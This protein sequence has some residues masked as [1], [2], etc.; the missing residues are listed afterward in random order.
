MDQT[1]EMAVM[2]ARKGVDNE[3]IERV[4]SA[5]RGHVA[6]APIVTA[7]LRERAPYERPVLRVK[8]RKTHEHIHHPVLDGIRVGLIAHGGTIEATMRELVEWCRPEWLASQA[9]PK[10]PNVRGLAAVVA[11]ARL[12]NGGVIR[13][14]RFTFLRVD[15]RAPHG[16]PRGS[17]NTVYRVEVV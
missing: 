12:K 5:M 17:G 2:L 15:P 6:P 8:D 3:T 1:I 10:R 4:V 11:T 14:L 9:D 16:S 7:P 13:G